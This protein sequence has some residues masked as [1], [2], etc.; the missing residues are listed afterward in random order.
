[1]GKL[2]DVEQ[3]EEYVDQTII[4]GESEGDRA[5]GMTGK[6][7][8]NAFNDTPNQDPGRTYERFETQ[9]NRGRNLRPNTRLS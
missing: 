2:K 6:D 3:K 8:E 4:S 7:F 5:K 1:M 9:K